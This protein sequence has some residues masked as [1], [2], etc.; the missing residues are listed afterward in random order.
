VG[1]PEG[2][3]A[4]EVARRWLDAVRRENFLDLRALTAVPFSVEGIELPEGTV[5]SQ[6]RG[7]L[8]SE[9]PSRGARGSGPKSVRLMAPNEAKLNTALAC[10]LRDGNLTSTI[11][12]PDWDPYDEA[13]TSQLK[14]VSLREVPR[15]LRRF[16]RALPALEHDHD[17]VAGTVY[18][19]TYAIT[20][21]VVVSKEARPRV[22]SIF[23]DELYDHTQEEEQETYG[24]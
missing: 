15:A 16:E 8:E 24:D 10:L 11:P 5:R 3:T 22:T 20:V 9:P 6:C 4:R 13:V 23:V 17:F 21:L 14:T 2:T 7:T 18:S 12:N 19:S 1:A